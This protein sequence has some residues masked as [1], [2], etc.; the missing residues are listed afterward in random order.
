MADG[1]CGFDLLL[2]QNQE[3]VERI[4]SSVLVLATATISW[5]I[6][7][8]ENA[9][10]PPWKV[11]RSFERKQIPQIVEI[12]RS[13]ENS[14]G[15]LATENKPREGKITNN[16]WPGGKISRPERWMILQ[17]KPAHATWA[18]FPCSDPKRKDYADT[19]P[20]L[21]R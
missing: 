9:R 5:S 10:T 1:A 4:L 19:E 13:V 3:D 2:V 21:R 16:R 12:I 18:P 15:R 7:M 11:H 14:Q 17:P 8:R 20:P 6:R